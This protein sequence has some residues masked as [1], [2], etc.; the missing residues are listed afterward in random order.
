VSAVRSDKGPLAPSAKV[1]L[2]RV[3]QDPSPRHEERVVTI[4]SSLTLAVSL[5]LLRERLCGAGS[6]DAH[7]TLRGMNSHGAK[8]DDG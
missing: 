5:S 1:L 8:T 4:L 2:F 7:N 3:R 6:R